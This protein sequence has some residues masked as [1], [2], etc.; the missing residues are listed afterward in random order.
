MATETILTVG[1]EVDSKC[2]KCK[3]LTNHKI[4][5]M[6][7]QEIVKVECNVCGGR[8]KYRPEKPVKAKT[9]KKAPA[10]KKAAAKK[11]PAKP[12]LTL[13]VKKAIEIF[14]KLMKGRNEADALPYSMTTQF[15]KNDL[16]NHP[17]FGIGVVTAIIPPNKIEL[18]FIEGPKLFICKLENAGSMATEPSPKGKKTK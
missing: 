9:K 16:I 5:A 3:D 13:A 2:T 6:V 1:D 8:H 17:S 7:E 10:K 12:K 4:V 11:K 14:T 15:G 18:T